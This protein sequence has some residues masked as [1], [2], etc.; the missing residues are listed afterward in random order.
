MTRRSMPVAP[1]LSVN[2]YANDVLADSRDVF[3]CIRETGPVVWL[4]R[5]RMYAIGRFADV[6]AALRNDAVYRSGAGVAA[7]RLSNHLGRHTTLF[8]DDEARTRRRKVLMRSLAAKALVD[9]EPQ[10]D[11]RAEALIERLLATDWLE[12]ATDFSAHLPI[13]VV[14]ELVG[15][16]RAVSDCCGGLR[17][18][19]TRSDR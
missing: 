5:H 12:A 19:S 2:L 8:S 18:P 15:G 14:A 17:Q 11:A 9:I 16:R 13:G 4:P 3:A 7:N 6:R 1:S 10:V